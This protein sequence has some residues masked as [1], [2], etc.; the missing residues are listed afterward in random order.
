[1]LGAERGTPEL[2]FCPWLLVVGKKYREIKI[3]RGF[4]IGG[5]RLGEAFAAR[6]R[7]SAHRLQ[8]GGNARPFAAR[9]VFAGSDFFFDSPEGVA[10][11]KAERGNDLLL[12]AIEAARL[13]PPPQVSARAHR[14]GEKL[15]GA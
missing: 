10:G 2:A 14:V 7:V 8:G 13:A 11:F 9:E 15:V 12:R 4:A 1:M 6:A 5:R 3:D